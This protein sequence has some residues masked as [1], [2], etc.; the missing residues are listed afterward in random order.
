[1]QVIIIKNTDSAKYERIL[2][3]YAKLIKGEMIYK[4]LV[5]IMPIISNWVKICRRC[6]REF[7]VKVDDNIMPQDL[8]KLSQEFRPE[9]RMILWV[10]SN[11]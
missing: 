6:G 11:I 2:T 7:I 10:K 9:C 8:K 4:S 3:L 1:M 5:I